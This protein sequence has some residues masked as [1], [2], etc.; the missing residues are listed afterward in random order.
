MQNPVEI[1]LKKRTGQEL[2]PDEMLFMV[3][4]YISGK[5]PDYQ[6][7]AFLMAIYFKGMT[8]EEI[9]N[10]TRVYIESGSQIEFP[11][12]LKTVDKHS[13][14]GVGDKITMTLAPIVAACGAYIPMIS[15]RGL[16]HTGG[17]LDKLESI[18]G[19]DTFMTEECFKEKVLQHKLAI[20]AQSEALVPADKK[21]Y[22]LRD[23]T[24][25]VESLPLICA[26]I[27]SKKIAEGAQNLVIDLKVGSG[28]FMKS[29]DDAKNLA[30]LLKYTGK[31]FG[32]RVS[33]V[34][35]RMDSPLG[36][37]IGNALEIKECIE[38][39][40]GKVIS[41]IDE[42]TKTLAVEMLLMTDIATDKNDALNQI[43]KV[44]KN[45]IALSKFAELVS[46]QEGDPKVVQNTSLLPSSKV[47]LNMVSNQKGYVK[48]IDSQKIGYALI[49]IGASRTS[50][51]SPLDMG[52]GAYLFK[53]IGDEIGMDEV[54]GEVHCECENTGK[55]VAQ[56]ILNAI[57]LSETKDFDIKDVILAIDT[58]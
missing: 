38:Y 1:I 36:Y 9:V 21:I 14:G 46:I 4:S 27:M 56:E 24:A 22:A 8:K 25:T 41:D 19:F 42:I 52:A 32:Q 30:E 18:P 26:S 51:Q 44:M 6:M 11:R 2:T 43:N 39:L 20:I 35:T 5:V 3:N 57:E 37:A 31:S 53:K 34:Y 49:K 7:S 23:V 15:G 10:L 58:F 29:M 17:T 12:E 45:G 13:T 54:I 16:G 50:L 33:V 47:I 28:A 55:I 48:N 40:Q